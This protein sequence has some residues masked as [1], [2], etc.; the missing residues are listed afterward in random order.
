MTVL[1]VYLGEQDDS[2]DE[3][4]FKNSLANLGDFCIRWS[5]VVEVV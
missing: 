1:A 4:V 5:K 2:A 3:S